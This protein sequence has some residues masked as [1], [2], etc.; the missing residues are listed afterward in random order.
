MRPNVFSQV[1]VLL[2]FFFFLGSAT[3]SP[4]LPEQ[5]AEQTIQLII[6]ACSLLV[7]AEA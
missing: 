2:I 6:F 4:S 7:Q 5:G 3:R 1:K